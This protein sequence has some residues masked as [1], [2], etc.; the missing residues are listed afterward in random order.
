[1]EAALG[2]P[3]L[4]M[5]VITLTHG[6]KTIVDVEDFEVVNVYLWYAHIHFGK[7][8]YAARKARFGEQN[9]VY[10]HRVI[11]Q[12]IGLIG[13][14][15]H[16]DR[17]GLNNQRSNLRRATQSQNQMNAGLRS[18]NTS[19]YKGVYFNKNKQAWA[20]S[21]KYDGQKSH[22]GYFDTAIKAAQAYDRAA[23]R[24]H[25]EF[26]VLNFPGK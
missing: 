3:E 5:P 9:P 2:F 15:D 19:G 21:I 22:L 6:Y 7:P 1:M 4:V 11:G 14:I 24:L 20:A 8:V 12:R 26:A 17:N 13:Q 25:G 23:M 18:T 16:K 10:L